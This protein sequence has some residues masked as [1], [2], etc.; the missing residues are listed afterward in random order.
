MQIDDKTKQYQLMLAQAKAL[1]ANEHNV[2]VNLANTSALLKTTFSNTV[3]AGWYLFD[4]QELVLGPFQ[5]QVSCGRIALGRGICGTAAATQSTIIVKN[6]AN[7]ANYI[8]C[9]SAAMS[10]IVVPVIQDQ[11]LLGVLDMDAK[12]TEAYEKNDQIYLE[13]LIELLLTHTNWD[14]SMFMI[15]NG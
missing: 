14:F 4:G 6:V 5:G 12:M 2:L 10:E 13:K 11:H 7:H 9:D 3:F 8:A 15:N 1:F